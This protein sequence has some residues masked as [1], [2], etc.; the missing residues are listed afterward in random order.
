MYNEEKLMKLA[1]KNP[2]GFYETLLPKVRSVS[3][4]WND[5]WVH[6]VIPD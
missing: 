2:L 4:N 1:G 3:I 5:E 6:H